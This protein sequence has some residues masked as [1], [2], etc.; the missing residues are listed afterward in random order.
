[1]IL[2]VE[3][4]IGDEV[5]VCNGGDAVVNGDAWMDRR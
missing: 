4:R 1:M 2:S 3:M 5:N